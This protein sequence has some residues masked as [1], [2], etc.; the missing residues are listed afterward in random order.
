M[1]LWLYLV[2][3]PVFVSLLPSLLSAQYRA[4][5]LFHGACDHEALLHSGLK[6]SA[7]KHDRVK[8]LKPWTRSLVVISFQPQTRKQEHAH[9]TTRVRRNVS[10]P[11]GFP[12]QLRSAGQRWVFLDKR[13]TNPAR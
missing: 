2:P 1:R 3:G 8:F 11:S 4:S 9:G 7:V 12:P 13:R 5:I 10:A 6:V